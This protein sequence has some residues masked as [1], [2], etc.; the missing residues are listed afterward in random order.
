MWALSHSLHLL[1]YNPLQYKNHSQLW[2]IPSSFC[3]HERHVV[4][5]LSMAPGGP[6]LLGFTNLGVVPPHFVSGMI[7][8]DGMSPLTLGGFCLS[9]I[10][11][12]GG[13]QLPV[14]RRGPRGEEPRPPASSP[15]MSLEMAPQPPSG[16]R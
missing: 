14:M 12:F 10:L 16:L 1:F 4:G 5:S 8:M 7:V 13:D 9:W 3:L 2:A 6:C 15:G 11:W